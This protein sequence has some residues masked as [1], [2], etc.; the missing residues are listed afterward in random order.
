MVPHTVQGVSGISSSNLNNEE[1]CC[2][3]SLAQRRK[4]NFSGVKALAQ[5]HRA[6]KKGC[7]RGRRPGAASCPSGTRRE[8]QSERASRRPTFLSLGGV[9]LPGP[10]PRMQSRKATRNLPKTQ[11][12]P[13][14]LSLGTPKP[15]QVCAQHLPSFHATLLGQCHLGPNS[16]NRTLRSSEGQVAWAPIASLS[17]TGSLN[18]PL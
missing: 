18:V 4:L 6:S 14:V 9:A 12:F 2:D 13:A 5:G 15:G 7:G 17:L 1:G 8:P 11:P 3:P 10:E 16:P